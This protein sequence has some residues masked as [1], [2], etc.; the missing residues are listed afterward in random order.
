MQLKKLLLFLL[1]YVVVI[2]EGPVEKFINSSISMGVNLQNLKSLS[3][4]KI[5]F[6][7]P[8]R[9]FWK[10]HSLIKQTDYKIKVLDKGGLPLLWNKAKK[11]KLLIIGLF[12]FVISMYILSSIVWFNN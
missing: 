5:Q 3:A 8:L 1:G 7:V 6:K 12:A 2:I 4:T 9:D 11:R 10:I